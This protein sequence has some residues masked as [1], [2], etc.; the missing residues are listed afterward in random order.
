MD[1]PVDTLK[2]HIEDALKWA[3]EMS[4]AWTNTLVGD[5]IDREA[6][7][8]KK[9]SNLEDWEAAH[10]SMIELVELCHD[11]ELQLD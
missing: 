2:E 6:E 8:L 11:A 9:A 1:M 10:K 3:S 7:I 4:E 5:F